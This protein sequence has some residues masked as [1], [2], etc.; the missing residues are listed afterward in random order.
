MT[1]VVNDDG[2][3]DDGGYDDGGYADGSNDDGGNDDGGYADSVDDAD[4]N[5]KAS[6]K[7]FPYEIPQQVGTMS[8][9]NTGTSIHRN[10]FSTDTPKTSQNG[11]STKHPNK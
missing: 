6:Q 11:F 5:T 8:V 2:G 4:R 1:T 7:R 10:S 9:R 3:Y